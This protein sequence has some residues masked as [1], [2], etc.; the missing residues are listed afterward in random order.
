MTTPYAWFNE[1]NGVTQRHISKPEVIMQ[2]TGLKDY[3]GVEIYEG[4][5][6]SDSHFIWKVVFDNLTSTYKAVCVNFNNPIM[7]NAELHVIL[8]KRL[9]AK[10]PCLVIGNIYENPE[11]LEDK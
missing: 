11:L 3:Y 5:I 8:S 1:S 2:C 9:L 7:N 6:I 10:M 4:D